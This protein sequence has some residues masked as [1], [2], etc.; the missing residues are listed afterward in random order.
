MI[1]LRA[2]CRI[3][4]P[5]LW[6]WAAPLPAHEVRPA[7]LEIVESPQNQVQILW[8]RPI[9]GDV[10]L[11]LHPQLSSGWLDQAPANI[12]RESGTMTTRW[13]VRAPTGSLDHQTVGVAGLSDSITDALLLLRFADGETVTRV[14]RPTAPSF[15]IDRAVPSGLPVAEYVLL[16]MRHIWTGYD[17]L[18]FVMGLMLLVGSGRRLWLT[19]TAFT[20]AHSIT[21]AATVLGLV[22]VASAPIEALIALS[23]LCVAVE[24]ARGLDG[25]GGLAFR[26]PWA[27]AFCFGLLHGF[28][29]AGALREVGLPPDAVPAALL[30]FNVG[31]EVGQI[32][33]VLL[34]AQAIRVL[35]LIGPRVRPTLE[36]SLPYLIGSLAAF[37]TIER[38]VASF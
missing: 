16:G 26:Y 8:R 33:F 24:L 37:W 10:A 22:N 2:L 9:A 31:I 34:V 6:W 5:L 38:T 30:L 36:A 19:I 20:V 11:P 27:L 7:Y 4:L 35:A 12:V 1:T 29:F 21:L 32:A 18:L 15:V 13:I 25:A 23:I 3:M 17:H 14:L 28:G